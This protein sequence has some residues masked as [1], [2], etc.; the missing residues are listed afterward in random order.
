MVKKFTIDNI[1]YIL[2]ENAKDNHQIIDYADGNDIWVHLDELPSGH[3]IIETNIIKDIY[4]YNAYNLIIEKSK[5]K[6]CKKI[7]YTYVKN[8]KKTKNPGEV[9]FIKKPEYK[10]IK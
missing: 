2:G 9:T 7:V 5:Y 3:C 1:N 10:N 4:L 8:I 6:Y